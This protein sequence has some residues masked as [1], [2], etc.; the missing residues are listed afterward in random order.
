MRFTD[1][2]LQLFF[3]YKKIKLRNTFHNIFT[4][5]TERLAHVCM[6]TLFSTVHFILSYS[7][8]DDIDDEKQ[9]DTLYGLLSFLSY[10]CFHSLRHAEC[11][12]ESMEEKNVAIIMHVPLPPQLH[13]LLNKSLN[14]RQTCFCALAHAVLF[15]CIFIHKQIP[16][17]R[18]REYQQ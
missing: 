13:L 5:S 9:D 7:N 18:K 2:C 6:Y 8:G 12:R 3:L 15:L 10:R 17:Y 16:E 4:I 14:Y 11:Q 1:A